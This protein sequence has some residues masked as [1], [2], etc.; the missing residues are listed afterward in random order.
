MPITVKV[1][2]SS[3]AE[4]WRS[5]LSAEQSRQAGMQLVIRIINR[6]IGG[7]DENDRPFTPYKTKRQSKA[8]TFVTRS[9]TGGVVDLHETGKMLDDLVV[10]NVTRKGFSL[11]FRSSRS[12]KLARIHNE[13]RGHMP[14]RSFLGVPQAWIRDILKAMIAKGQR[15]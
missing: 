7:H 5:K 4:Q 12:A 13:G 1:V 9:R 15:R 14:Q 10:S 11:A 8:R 3:L 6:T 2:G